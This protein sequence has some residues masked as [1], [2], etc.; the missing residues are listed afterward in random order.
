MKQLLLSLVTAAVLAGC[1]QSNAA[2]P[3]AAPAAGALTEQSQS[4]HATA[5]GSVTPLRHADLAF[6][7]GGRVVQVLVTEGD[8]VKA[9]QPLVKLDA[10]ELKA[11]LSQAQADLARMQAGARAEEIAAAQANVAIATA[12]VKAAQ[13]ELDNA[14]N[15]SAQAADVA[16]AQAQVAQTQTQLK[17]VQDGY[18]SITTGIETLKEYGRSGSTLSRYAEQTRVQLAAAQAAYHAAQQRLTLAA[19]SQNDT[20]RSAQ[21]RLNIALGQQN[22]AQ[23]QL[24][25]LKA[26]STQEQIEAATARVIQAQAA[27]DD[28]ALVAPFD[29]T[30]AELN[31][32]LGEMVGPG[33]RVASLADLKQWQVETDDLGELD[34]VN[35]Q[36]NAP[37]TITVDALPGVLLTGQV[38]SIMPRSTVKRGDVTYTAKVT[39]ADPDPRL[40]WGMTASADFPGR[41]LAAASSPATEAARTSSGSSAG[42][43]GYVTPIRHADLAFG[44]SGSVEQV[45][46]T[47]GEQV[48][49]GQ[50]LVKLQ[51]TALQAALA[52][53]Q[54]DL[55]NLQ[56]GA[57]PEEITAAQA[58]LD[59]AQSQL[60]LAQAELSRLQNG[61]L[62]V[63]IAAAQAD[64]ARAQAELKVAQDSYDALVL[65]SGH[66]VA[67]DRQAPGRGLGAYEE[68][69]RSQLAATQ[70]AYAAALK[71]VAEARVNADHSLQ[72]ARAG[73][74]VAAAQ[75]DAAQARL[76]LITA[77]A[78]SQQIDMAKARVAQAQAALDEATLVAPFDG[79]IAEVA[80]NPGEIAVPGTRLISLADVTHW[81]VDTDDLTEKEVVGVAP[82]TPA[83]ITLDALPGVTFN[84]QV[85]SITPRSTTK[86]GDV[87]YTVKLSI[88]DPD[89]RVRWGMTAAVDILDK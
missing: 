4:S 30:I 46:V 21:A 6:H 24:D 67:D 87:T 60:E 36:S 22:A 61:A 29:G 70:A 43:T 75:R 52:Q 73:V 69:K 1:T 82:G 37:V 31:T 71:R 42:V 38:K 45:L 16:S 86:S 44:T 79:T 62:T 40:M 56:N 63:S 2:A 8:Q 88:A 78:T 19:T 68:Q 5:Q 34:V 66:G 33:S 55:K 28:T 39:I 50:P 53:A 10:A 83:S 14:K 26:G 58:N 72:A 48:K 54:A 3:T 20:V 35:V 77:G 89:P 13:V 57:R 85:M 25:L 47:A 32:N 11:I 9:G 65:G 59:I 49:A 51:D 84:G 7:T 64:A 23:A 12:Q 41:P 15:G 74:D 17:A 81:E 27:L 76:A 18:D 80:V